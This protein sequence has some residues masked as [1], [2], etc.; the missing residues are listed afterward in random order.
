MM[1]LFDECLRVI[2]S[3]NQEGVEYVVIG[4][5]AI[6]LHGLVRA[7]EDLDIFVRPDPQNIV[8]LRTALRRIWDDPCIDDITTEDLCGEYPTIRYGPPQG[9][10]YL[11]LLTRIGET[12]HFDDLEAV[13]QKF[14]GVTIRFAS[15]AT[16]YRMK[17]GTV[18][19]RD[20]ADAA[21]LAQAFHLGPEEE[22]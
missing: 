13:E 5:V 21:A 8:R 12:V 10:L 4:G 3:F 9:N 6:N 14:E 7:T 19:P 1:D 15:P 22:S 17:R 16:L 18:R 2:D 11:D 20:H